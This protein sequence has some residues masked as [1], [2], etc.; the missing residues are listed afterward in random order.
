MSA[1]TVRTRFAPAPTGYM[2]V[3]NVHT[4]LFAWLFARHNN[5]QFILRIEDTDEVRSTPEALEHIYAGLRWIGLD[6]DEGP[7]IGGPYA[8]YIQSQRLDL[9]QEYVRKLV[10]EGR[11]YECFCTPEELEQR[12]KLM[13]ARGIPPRY[14]GRCRDL[15]ERERRRLRDEGRP[16]AI[17]FRMPQTGTTVVH[18]L[19]R[20]DVPFDNSTLGDFVILKRSG[21]PTYH[22]AVVVDDYLMRITHVVR[23]EEH[24]SNTPRHLQ[25]IEALGFDPPQYVHL[26]IIL[27]PDRTKLS[28]RHGAV[29]MMEYAQRGFLP[30]AMFNFLA[31]LGWSPGGDREILD[32]AEIIEKFSLDGCSKSPA[33]FDLSKAEWINGEYIKKL[34]LERLVE[35]LRPYLE[36]AG[37]FEKNPT[38]ERLQW[39]GRV[40]DLMRERAKL[41]TTYVT[42]AR[43]FFTDD[44]P[45]EERAVSKWLSRPEVADILA[46]LAAAYAGLH[47]WNA[48][49]IEATTRALADARGLRAAEVIHPCRAAVTGTTIGPSLFHILELLSKE[50]V[51]NRL[52]RTES[53][54]RTGEIAKVAVAETPSDGR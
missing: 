53:L 11:A 32:R 38:P 1:G 26:P 23:A 2:H 22:M 46:D 45:Y 9:Y 8:P 43:Y 25:L 7:D 24:L 19:L 16:F 49:T 50:D 36:E 48:E 15:S 33:I 35:A 4:A 13:L 14:D 52:R 6:W 40:A 54:V 47:D 10:D 21:Y 3:G 44:Y 27:G 18:D 28:K 17:N 42:W 29:S 41:L 30:E 51:V 5:G 37:L 20:G 12:R 31:L 34:P 39:L